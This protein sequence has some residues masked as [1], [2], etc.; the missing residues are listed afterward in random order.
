MTDVLVTELNGATVIQNPD[1]P[2]A[3]LMTT[4]PVDYE[5]VYGTNGRPL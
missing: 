3:W 5:Q 1:N 4:K 2:D